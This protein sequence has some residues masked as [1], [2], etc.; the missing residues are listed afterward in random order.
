M[1]SRTLVNH[2]LVKKAVSLV[3][4]VPEV[5]PVFAGVTAAASASAVTFESA[6]EI[7]RSCAL[8]FRAG[9]LF[10]LQAVVDFATNDA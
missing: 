6:L 1:Y 3:P 8:P 4:S 9:D 2:D 10:V 7:V 5:S